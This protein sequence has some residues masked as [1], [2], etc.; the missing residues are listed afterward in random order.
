MFLLYSPTCNP[1]PIARV[2][3]LF[4]MR[5]F[6]TGLHCGL[7][8]TFCSRDEESAMGSNTLVLEG[9]AGMNAWRPH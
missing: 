8:G 2:Q 7:F 4:P 3:I 9:L 6:C 1:T 5:E